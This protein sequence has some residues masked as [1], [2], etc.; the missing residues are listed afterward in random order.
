M[1]PELMYIIAFVVW[2]N[3]Y[4]REELTRPTVSRYGD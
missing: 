2:A 4:G 1:S 3:S